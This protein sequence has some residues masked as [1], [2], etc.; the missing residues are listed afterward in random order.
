MASVPVNV[1][2][3]RVDN[4]RQ[5]VQRRRRESRRAARRWTLAGRL[6]PGNRCQHGAA[7]SVETGGSPN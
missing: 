1:D 2:T 4:E 7:D 6:G 5:G 3:A